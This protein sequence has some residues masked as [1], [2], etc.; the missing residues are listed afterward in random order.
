MTDT[1]Q[2]TRTPPV[3]S[4]SKM[5]R[6]AISNREPDDQRPKQAQTTIPQTRPASAAAP[7][8]N[9]GNV[10]VEKAVQRPQYKQIVPA[11]DPEAVKNVFAKIMDTEVTV[12]VK[13]LMAAS[14]ELR[15]KNRDFITGK[16][17]PTDDNGQEIGTIMYSTTKDSANP[18]GANIETIAP[19]NVRLRMIAVWI[20]GS[21]P[22]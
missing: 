22:A 13:Q 4:G 18:G 14:P 12:M 3:A 9:G 19:A 11:A 5:V 1:Q 6:F 17:E 15:K 20:N 21:I 8:P 10:L 16:R 7:A 2:R